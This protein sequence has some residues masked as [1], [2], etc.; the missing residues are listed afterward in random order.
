MEPATARNPV[1][2][3]VAAR[4]VLL[5][6]TEN[7]LY[8]RARLAGRDPAEVMTEF[9]AGHELCLLCGNWHRKEPAS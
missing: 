5:R 2:I 4:Q 6:S 3:P 8:I 1:L 9:A 7:R